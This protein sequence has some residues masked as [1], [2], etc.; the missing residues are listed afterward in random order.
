DRSR[1]ADRI[2][3]GQRSH[4]KRG[5][6]REE[7]VRPSRHLAVAALLVLAAA[8]AHAAEELPALAGPPLV[9]L[10]VPGFSNAI[11]SVPIGTKRPMPLLLATHG[12]Y[13][14]PEWQCETW[15]QIIGDAGFVLCPRGVRRPDSPGAD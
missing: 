3:G 8:M 5:G 15:R 13:D 14:R 9:S 1:S 2:D 6:R 12:N 11:V 4:R 10:A 7:E